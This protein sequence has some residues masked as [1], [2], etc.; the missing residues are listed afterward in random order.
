MVKTAAL[1][2]EEREYAQTE[3]QKVLKF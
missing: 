3:M 1:L 2:G